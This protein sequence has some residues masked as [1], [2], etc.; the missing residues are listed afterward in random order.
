MKYDRKEDFNF[1]RW[2]ASVKKRDYF[3]CQICERR[4]VELN[5]HHVNSWDMF[6]DERYDLDNGITLC[7]NCHHRFHNAYGYGNNTRI[8]FE[9]FQEAS[10]MIKR[11]I[12]KK[13]KLADIVGHIVADLESKYK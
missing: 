3:T 11:S 4:G 7:T 10:E 9:E 1:I 6:P 12:Q 8:Q 2:A 5:A 13:H